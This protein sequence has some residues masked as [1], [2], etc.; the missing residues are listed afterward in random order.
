[1]VKKRTKI[2]SPNFSTAKMKGDQIKST[3]KVTKPKRGVNSLKII[4]WRSRKNVLPVLK[5]WYQP[6]QLFHQFIRPRQI[7]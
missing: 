6:F 2:L 4:T 7:S 1:M 5:I 3:L